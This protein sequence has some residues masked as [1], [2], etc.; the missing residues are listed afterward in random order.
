MPRYRVVSRGGII[1]AI[2]AVN[3][4]IPLERLPLLPG[5]W[6]RHTSRDHHDVIDGR[7]IDLKVGEASDSRVFDREHQVVLLNELPGRSSIIRLVQRDGIITAISAL[8]GG[9]LVEELDLRQRPWRLQH[10]D[11]EWTPVVLILCCVLVMRHHRN[12]FRDHP[13]VLLHAGQQ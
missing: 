7:L 12:Y 13:V 3:S 11:D 5:S 1:T 2:H 10:R 8:P 9:A 4:P 6:Q